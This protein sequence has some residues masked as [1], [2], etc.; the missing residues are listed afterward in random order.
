ME[1]IAD[2]TAGVS[3]QA[4]DRRSSAGYLIV[5]RR[6]LWSEQSA[7]DKQSRHCFLSLR[8]HSNFRLNFAAIMHTQKDA[9]VVQKKLKSSAISCALQC[10]THLSLAKWP[11]Q[12][13]L[14][15]WWRGRLFFFFRSLPT[16]SMAEKRKH[17]TVNTLFSFGFKRSRS[18]SR[19]TNKHLGIT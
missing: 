15:V 4:G 19:W 14:G 9:S 17:Q 10:R 7:R 2:N 11:G 16:D 18:S 13:R 3:K 12:P 6:L 1:T 5:C 8:Q